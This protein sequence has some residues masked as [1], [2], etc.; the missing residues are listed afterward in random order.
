[1][2][3]WILIQ[4][5]EHCNPFMCC[6]VWGFLISHPCL[7]VCVRRVFVNGS[8]LSLPTCC[9][10]EG[11]PQS[12]H[13]RDWH[14]LKMLRSVPSCP[15][16]AGREEWGL[17]AASVCRGHVGGAV[18]RHLTPTEEHAPL[19]M[20]MKPKDPSVPLDTIVQNSEKSRRTLAAVD[21]CVLRNTHRHGDTWTGEIVQ[22]VPTVNSFKVLRHWL[23]ESAVIRPCH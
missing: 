19:Y 6:P 1:M 18:W 2:F 15:T 8:C 7:S 12:G 16:P 13:W 17:L 10:S 14:D 20:Q 21:M 22:R 23:M 9:S 4:C 3:Y 11:W 5:Q